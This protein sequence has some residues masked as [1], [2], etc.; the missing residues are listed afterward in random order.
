MCGS[1]LCAGG[2]HPENLVGIAEKVVGPAH[3]SKGKEGGA[4]QG[5]AAGGVG[6][7]A[8]VQQLQ[9]RGKNQAGSLA[10]AA[11]QSA[12]EQKGQHLSVRPCLFVSRCVGEVRKVLPRALRPHGAACACIFASASP[13]QC[14]RLQ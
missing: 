6:K 4:G 9:Q 12:G 3:G 5:V 14:L 10:D 13:A 2:I 11:A 1:G 8:P 7:L